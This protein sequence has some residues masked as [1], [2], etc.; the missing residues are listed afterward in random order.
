L[1]YGELTGAGSVSESTRIFEE[2][3]ER[4]Q[5]GT[6]QKRYNYA[7]KVYEIYGS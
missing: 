7:Q 4:P 5:P 1:C 3:F 6:F 2:L